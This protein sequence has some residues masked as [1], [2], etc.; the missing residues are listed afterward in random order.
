MRRPYAATSKQGTPP[1]RGREQWVSSAPAKAS[2]PAR[3]AQFVLIWINGHCLETCD[4]HHT[5]QRAD[6][7]LFTRH[8]PASQ[9]TEAAAGFSYRPLR[10]FASPSRRRVRERA[11]YSNQV[12]PGHRQRAHG[13]GLPMHRIERRINR[14]ASRSQRIVRWHSRPVVWVFP[15]SGCE[16]ARSDHGMTEEL[17]FPTRC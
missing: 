8:S 6:L 3:C 7:V 10:A 15:R 11:P 5:K 4:V 13:I 16:L 2:V 9:G 14:L 17:E 12:V 1:T